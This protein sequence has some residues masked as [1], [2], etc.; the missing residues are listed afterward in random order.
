MDDANLMLLKKK[1]KAI[2]QYKGQGTQLIS[3]YLPPDADRSSATKQLTDEMSQS[4]NIKSAQTRKNVQ[5]ALKRIINY[6]KQIDFKL[7]ETGLVLFSGDVSTNPS[8]SDVILL[9]IVPPVRLTT[10]LYWC[11]STFH[12]APLEDMAQTD[13]VY[14]LVVMDKRE[15]T[16]AI[17][18]GKSKE[19]LF[20]ESSNVP[21]KTKAGGQCLKEAFISLSNGDLIDISNISSKTSLTSVNFNKDKIVNSKITKKWSVTKNKTYIIKT[22]APGMEIKASEDHIFFVLTPDGIIQKI[23]KELTLKDYLLFPEKLSYKNKSYSFNTKKYI[24][25]LNKPSIKIPSKLDNNFSQFLG[26]LLGDGSIETDRLTFY[27]SRKDVILEYKKLFDKYFNINSSLTFRDSKNYYQLRVT[28]TALVR[29]IK[30]EF[31]EIK[32]ARDSLIPSKILTSSDKVLSYF[33]KGLYDAEGYVNFSKKSIDIGINNKQLAL[34]I[35]LVLF[36]FSIIGSLQE[37]DNKQNP[38]TDNHRFVISISDKESLASF[39]KNINFTSLEKQKKIKAF[40]KIKTKK[41]FSRT[42]PV[43]GRKVREVIQSHGYNLEL[44]PKVSSFFNNNRMISK[45]VFKTS[46]LDYVKDK[47]LLKD[48]NKFYIMPY[49]CAK[50][51]SINIENKKTTMTDISVINKSFIANG[52]IVHNSAH[53]FERLRDKYEEE[54]YKR[55]GEKVNTAFVNLENFKGMIVGGPGLTKNE[56]LEIGDLDHRIKDKILGTVDTSYTDESGIKE[57]LDKSEDI[58]KETGLVHERKL[59]NKFFENLAK[60]GLANYGFQDV[61]DALNIGK[62]STVLVSE[63]LEWTV[64]IFKCLSDKSRFIKIVKNKDEVSDAISKFENSQ[65]DCMQGKAELVEE[66]DIYDYFID[67]SKN[68]SAKVELISVETLEGKQFFETFGGLAAFLRYR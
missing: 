36:R 58:L 3:L 23:S 4:S 48:L 56:F 8:K 59:I 29:L 10:K 19:I 26:Y 53:R 2:K 37:Y 28:S 63:G 62:A 15:A 21:G 65:D 6:L 31:K 18:R 54:F 25:K 57:I 5:A 55:V 20:S 40:Q 39:E 16:V 35:Q 1:V 43:Y 64:L 51:N 13:D 41:S 50:I 66:V 61:I 9:A 11:D 27:E 24:S 52:L 46:I 47:S 30:E 44:F 49:F 22:K 17:L 32:K 12:I 60:T 7:P 45:S 33:L 34:Q 38:Y 42:L 68:T 14:G 67:I